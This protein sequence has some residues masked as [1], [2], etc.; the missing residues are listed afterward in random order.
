MQPE[1]MAVALAFSEMGLSFRSVFPDPIDQLSGYARHRWAVMKTKTYLIVHAVPPIDEF[2]TSFWEEWYSY[3]GGHV[4]HHVLFTNPPS[5]PYHDIYDP[6]TKPDDLHPE[7]IFGRKW[8]VVEEP[9]MFAWGV[10]NLLI[11]K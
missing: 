3:K 4:I 11:N 5:V 7:E 8:Y 1:H 2:D 9:G 6:P 10:K